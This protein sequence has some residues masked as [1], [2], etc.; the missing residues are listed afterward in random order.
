[1][2]RVSSLYIKIQ[3]M[4]PYLWMM[5][6]LLESLTSLGLIQIALTQQNGYHLLDNGRRK[7]VKLLRMLMENHR[8][9]TA[10][11]SGSK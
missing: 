2:V 6:Q 10:T 4:Q 8:Y 11:T 1:M 9:Q 5:V 3:H 7:A